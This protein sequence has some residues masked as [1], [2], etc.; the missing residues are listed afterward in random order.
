MD[1]REYVCNQMYKQHD[2]L[3]KGSWTDADKLEYMELNIAPYS[4]YWRMGMKKALKHAIRLLRE[5]EAKADRKTENSSEKPNNCKPQNYCD[6][7]LYT[8]T[9]DSK[10]F[11]Y[12]CT[13]KATISKMEQVE[14]EPKTQTETQNSN[15]TFK[16]LEYCDICDHKGCEECIANALDE[17]CIPSQFKKQIEDECAKEYEELG[18]KELKELIKADRKDEPQTEAFEEP[19]YYDPALWE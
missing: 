17:H 19:S 7:C 4:R 12:A 9:C 1:R 2:L 15:L 8:D 18:L 16:T 13:S 10:E 14:D 11:F 5:E 3:R 6:D